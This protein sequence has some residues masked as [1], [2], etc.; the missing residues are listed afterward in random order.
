MWTYFYGQYGDLRVKGNFERCLGAMLRYKHVAYLE[1]DVER[2]RREFW[3]GEPTY[4]RLFALIQRQ[5][6]EREGKPRWGDQTGLIERYADPIFAAYPGAKLLHMVRDPRDRYEAAR[7]RHARGQGRVGAATARWL[8]SVGLGERNERRYPERY[9][10]VRYEELVREPE[11]TL[12][13][14]CAFLDEPYMPA[15]LSMAGAPEHREK[16]SRSA[17]EVPAG[18]APLSSAY[19]GRYRGVVEERELAFM[20]LHAGRAMRDHGYA[21]EPVRLPARD[22][23]RFA[24]LD[25]P[26]NLTRMLGWRMWEAVQHSFPAQV[27]RKPGAEALIV[28]SDAG[29]WGSQAP[30]KI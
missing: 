28:R 25:W 11:A 9:R 20:Q 13:A 27:G 22:A 19:I 12:R 29:E 24:L 6:A 30:E 15:M 17:P 18:Q 14:V 2:V 26:A 5:Y 7:A 16:F 1:P 10:V 3:Q 4:A 8:Y 23:L 21:L